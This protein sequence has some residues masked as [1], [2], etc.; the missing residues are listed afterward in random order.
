MHTFYSPTEISIQTFG[1]E[2]GLGPNIGGK[3]WIEERLKR[4][5]IRD[6]TM[7]LNGLKKKL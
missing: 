1:N 3:Q 7:K 5:R 4:E 6:F 2:G